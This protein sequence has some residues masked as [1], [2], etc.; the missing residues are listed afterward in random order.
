MSLS[1]YCRIHC[2]SLFL[3]L[4]ISVVLLACDN[5]GISQSNN[6]TITHASWDKET[7]T[8]TVAGRSDGTSEIELID[9]LA[10]NLL[11]STT[12]DVGAWQI[13]INGFVC[14]V[15]ASQ[16]DNKVSKSIENAPEECDTLKVK[17]SQ[18][19]ALASP[20]IKAVADQNISPL[21]AWPEGLMLSPAQNMTIMAGQS[22][23]FAAA[24]S[25]ALGRI[26][27]SYHWDFGGAGPNSNAQ[28]PGQIFFNVPGAF[29]VKL[30]VTNSLGI[31]DPTPSTRVIIVQ[32]STNAPGYGTPYPTPTPSPAPPP[33]T[34]VAVPAPLIMSPMSGNVTIS[35]G[36]SLDFIGSG[37]GPAIGP[38]SLRY[39]WDFGGAVTSPVPS[40]TAKTPGRLS[41]LSAGTFIVRLN[42]QTNFGVSNL[43]AAQVVVTVLAGNVSNNLPPTGVIS[44]PTTNVVIRPGDAL[45]FSGDGFDPENNQPLHYLWD[46][47]GASEDSTQR[48]PGLI[49]FNNPGVYTVQFIAA[50]A[51]GLADPNPPVRI[52]TVQ[53][54][55]NQGSNVRQNQIIS[56]ASNMTIQVGGSVTFSA[57][58]ATGLPEA[59]LTPLQYFW[60]F[61]EAAPTSNLL[62]PGAITFTQPGIYNVSFLVGNTNGILVG[63]EV[64]RTITV[65]GSSLPPQRPQQS[66]I[67]SPEGSDITIGAGDQ[68]IFAARP[69]TP[70]AGYKVEY[71]WFFSDNI[72]PASSQSNA[73]SVT[74]Q[75]GGQYQVTLN[76]RMVD[77]FGNVLTRSRAVIIVRVIDNAV[78]A[79]GILSPANDII[80]NA[81]SEVNFQGDSLDSRQY[82][83]IRYLWRFVRLSGFGNANLLPDLTVQNPGRILFRNAGEFEVRFEVSGTN[84]VTGVTS[85]IGGTRRIIVNRPGPFPPQPPS[86]GIGRLQGNILSP[87]DNATIRVGTS[88]NFTGSSI[89]A[90]T[91]TVS[92]FWDFGGASLNTSVQNPGT[93]TFNRVGSYLVTL[94]VRTSVGDFDSTP[95]SIRVNVTP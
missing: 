74:F 28:N 51:T 26:P 56:P 93:V 49:R 34:P 5:P 44:S 30:T 92:Y 13:K 11:A 35:V 16:D 62:N 21:A 65:I 2:F 8:L 71:Q 63:Q 61:D 23:N 67:L 43:Q 19:R 76:V 78:L 54:T 20:S 83:G 89:G 10:A 73:G 7:A 40:S 90:T 46:F 86:G 37:F 33:N 66:P 25:D 48:V 52:I 60:N 17:R 94:N 53:S 22:V 82:L 58:A 1:H 70:P 87:R 57:Q 47:G 80:I 14:Q 41:F 88:L 12:A 85:R 36:E 59:R 81:G 42:V 50:D 4:F 75:R 55:G 24:A 6:L 64:R 18:S 38:S 77:T 68:L 3:I 39:F 45:F 29:V 69:V 9:D 32:S 15:T 72:A 84:R 27:I 95:P 31:S 79:G 91:Q